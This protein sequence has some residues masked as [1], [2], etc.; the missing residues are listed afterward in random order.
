[1]E[2]Y[3]SKSMERTTVVV[4]IL[5]VYAAHAHIAANIPSVFLV[6]LQIR[7]E[8]NKKST[9]NVYMGTHAQSGI[10]RAAKL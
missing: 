2:L 6:V 3:I 9:V 5:A 1:M 10:H 7:I 4:F 8:N